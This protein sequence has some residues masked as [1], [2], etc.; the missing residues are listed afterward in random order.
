MHGLRTSEW[1]ERKA[2]IECAQQVG[3][4]VVA[5]VGAAGLYGVGEQQRAERLRHVGGRVEG[6]D[7]EAAVLVC[8]R[9]EQ[10]VELLLQPRVGG[11]EARGRSSGARLVG[12]VVARV[13]DDER[14]RRRALR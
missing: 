9:G 4:T 7:D 5:V 3:R 13:G 6:D 10:W 1:I 2:V 14:E 12:A 8:L 11:G